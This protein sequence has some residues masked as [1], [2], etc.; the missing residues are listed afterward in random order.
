MNFIVQI[1][2]KANALSKKNGTKGFVAICYLE[3]LKKCKLPIKF[4]VSFA[5][6]LKRIFN[7]HL[8]KCIFVDPPILFKNIYYVIKGFIDKKTKKKVVFMKNEEE[9][10]DFLED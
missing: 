10:D 7:D 8:Y 4:Y 6:L 9:I 3:N 5:K 1:F 2:F